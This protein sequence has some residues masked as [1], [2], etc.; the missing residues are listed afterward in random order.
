MPSKVNNNNN[1]NNNNSCFHHQ[2]ATDLDSDD[3]NLKYVIT[4]AA[5]QGFLLKSI[6]GGDGEDGGDESTVELLEVGDVFYQH[7]ID[8]KKI[9]YEHTGR[10]SSSASA[11][12]NLHSDAFGRLIGLN[13]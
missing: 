3:K 1:N 8:D 4:Y 7:D 10:R 12:T 2:Q 9:S 5:Q 13:I 6:N 11:S